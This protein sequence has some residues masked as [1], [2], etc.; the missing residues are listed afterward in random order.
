MKPTLR[1]CLLVALFALGA[2]QQGNPVFARPT[3]PEPNSAGTSRL[4]TTPANC[5]RWPI[6]A[7]GWW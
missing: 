5:G 1:L 4:T 3:L 2:C 7:G 6:F